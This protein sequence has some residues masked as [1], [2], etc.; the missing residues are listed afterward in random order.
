M[1][2]SKIFDSRLGRE[3]KWKNKKSGKIRE[4]RWEYFWHSD[5]FLI[6]IKGIRRHSTRNDSPEFGNWEF[7]EG[8]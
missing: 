6:D 1:D 7:I 4:G 8:P 3:G 5:C 2:F